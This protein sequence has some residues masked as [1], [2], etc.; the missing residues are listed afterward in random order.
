M[1]CVIRNNDLIFFKKTD[2]IKY[3]DDKNMRICYCLPKN[4]PE[5]LIRKTY[6]YKMLY[7]IFSR[8]RCDSYILFCHKPIVQT[9]DDRVL[10]RLTTQLLYNHLGR[11]HQVH[12]YHLSR[13]QSLKLLREIYSTQE[14]SLLNTF[15]YNRAFFRL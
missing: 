8:L 14:F 1:P 15:T 12:I 13:Q 5:M 6:L 10:H 7:Q 3:Y 11:V 4:D 9:T 2:L